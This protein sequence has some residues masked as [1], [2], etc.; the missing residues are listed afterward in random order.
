MLGT[1]DLPALTDASRLQVTANQELA[2][3]R[4]PALQAIDA[5][6]IDSQAL[7]ELTLP[8]LASVSQRLEIRN[9]QLADLRGL[10]GLR[11]VGAG[12]GLANL[13]LDGNAALTSL[14]GLE[15]LGMITGKLAL[16]DDARLASLAGLAALT[17][18]GGTVTVTG[19]PAL[20]PDEVAAFIARVHP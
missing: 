15:Q 3:V 7:T 18:V 4:L 11:A 17:S 10:A 5:A 19:D 12:R 16:T 8:G 13:V 6:V 9:T 2:A 1:L 20:S 14:A